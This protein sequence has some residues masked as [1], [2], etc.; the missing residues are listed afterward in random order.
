MITNPIKAVIDRIEESKAVIRS[1]D[2]QILLWPI[3]NLPENTAEGSV[4]YIS[5]TKSEIEERERENLAK[6]ILNEIMNQE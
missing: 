4:V 2:G 1:D 3:E 5:L 6:E